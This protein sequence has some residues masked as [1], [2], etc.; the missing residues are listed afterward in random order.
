MAIHYPLGCGRQRWSVAPPCATPYP[1][2][3]NNEIAWVAG[4][5]AA[6][7]DAGIQLYPQ[8]TAPGVDVHL[9]GLCRRTDLL[10]THERSSY[11]CDKFIL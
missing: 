10:H 4:K 2:P 9:N 3:V 6:Q 11:Q 7:L 1:L 5:C 8:I